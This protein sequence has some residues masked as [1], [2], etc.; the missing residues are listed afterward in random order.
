MQNEGNDWTWA[1]S[2]SEAELGNYYV[3][4][5][6]I[7][8]QLQ[9]KG[10]SPSAAYLGLLSFQT[11]SHLERSASCLFFCKLKVSSSATA[12]HPQEG[13]TGAQRHLCCSRLALIRWVWTKI[14][15]AFS[16]KCQLQKFTEMSMNAK[17]T[18][19]WKAM[20]IYVSVSTKVSSVVKNRER[21]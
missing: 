10:F 3:G 1:G 12:T 19:W 17:Q 2:I 18:F 13:P 11:G 21:L 7:M 15:T 14:I 6:C 4:F 8:H 5:T 20:E 16:T 9:V